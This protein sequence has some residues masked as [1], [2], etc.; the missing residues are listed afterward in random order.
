MDTSAVILLGTLKKNEQSNTEVLCDFFAERAGQKGLECELVKLVDHNILPGTYSDMGSGDDWPAVLDRILKANFIVF[1]TPVWWGG[2]SSEM[3]KVIERL[4]EIHDEILS[5]KPSRLD[6]K[7]GGI[8]ITGDSDGS[9]HIIASISNFYN[10]V[11]ILI[12]PFATLS[13]LS[14]KHKK[15]AETSRKELLKLYETDYAKSADKM[16]NQLIKYAPK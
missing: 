14:E 4:D 8:L 13:V 9:R 7:L 12:P 6:G 10:A 11:G 2:H 5:G 15:G 3:Q 1:A 16:I